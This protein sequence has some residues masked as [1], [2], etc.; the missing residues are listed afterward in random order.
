MAILFVGGRSKKTGEAPS[1]TQKLAVSDLS[2]YDKDTDAD[3]YPD[4]IEIEVGLDP[5]VSEYTRCKSGG[6]SDSQ[7]TNSEPKNHN[8]LIILDASGSMT[9]GG[10]PNRMEIAKT[11]IKSYVAKASE[12]T[13]IGL[14]IYGHKGSNSESDKATSCATAEVIAPIGSV[15]SAS[16]EETLS[17]VGPVGWTLMGKALE[18]AGKSFMGKEGEDNEVILLSDGEET[19]G[20][21]PTG[22][23]LALKNS[24]AK[25]IINVIGFAVDAEAQTQLNQISTSGGGL[26]SLAN[27]LTELDRKFNELYENGLRR[28]ED[29]KCNVADAEVFRVCYDASFNKVRDYIAKQKLLLYDKKIT[30]AEYETLDSLS[31]ALYAQQKKISAEETQKAIDKFKQ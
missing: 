16:I 12:S 10:T 15:N 19:C 21:D 25:V 5:M 28:Y 2:Q 11:A 9:L 13:Q 8:V 31:T 18:E 29:I 3:G 7:L 6:C 24:S 14:M 27:N 26:F 20:S 17:T 23:A 1:L 30:R 4:F 22:K